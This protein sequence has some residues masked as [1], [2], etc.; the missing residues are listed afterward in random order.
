MTPA[1]PDAA[2]EAAGQA[3]QRYMVGDDLECV[4]RGATLDMADGWVRAID[5]ADEVFDA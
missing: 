5:E 2:V 1:I 3:L 4:P